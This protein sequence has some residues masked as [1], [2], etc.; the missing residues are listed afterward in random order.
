V[1]VEGATVHLCHGATAML[2]LG[3]ILTFSGIGLMCWLIFTLTVYALPFFVGLTAGMAAL[4][5]GAGI[6]GAL[7]VGL[8]LERS[9]SASDRSFLRL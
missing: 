5:N 7:L 2:A 6:L 8:S 4:H 9:R 3:L 1:V